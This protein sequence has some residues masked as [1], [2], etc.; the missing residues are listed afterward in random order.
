M[1]KPLDS[2]PETAKAMPPLELVD[3]SF[4]TDLTA[5]PAEAVDLTEDERFGPA[6]NVDHWTKHM[7]CEDCCLHMRSLKKKWSF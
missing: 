3:S 1:E 5:A 7:K 6:A 4:Q 2:Q